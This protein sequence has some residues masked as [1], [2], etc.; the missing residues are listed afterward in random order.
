MSTQLGHMYSVNRN[1]VSPVR[2][3]CTPLEGKLRHRMD[4]AGEGHH[5]RWKGVTF[6]NQAVNTLWSSQPYPA[7]AAIDTSD[8][9]LGAEGAATLAATASLPRIDKESV[10][11]LTAD[12]PNVL[13]E[14]EE[15][16]SYVIGGIVDKNRYKVGWL[17]C[18][19][20]PLVDEDKPVTDQLTE[21]YM[22]VNHSIRTCV[23]TLPKSTALGMPRCQFRSTLSCRPGR[24]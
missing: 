22:N 1:A 18:V 13:S 17:C 11:Y 14:L 21:A 2:I 5:T 20:I 16:K 8:G 4:T 9:T 24:Y 6:L 10:I 12:S 23:T 15:G 3:I 19:P 7:P